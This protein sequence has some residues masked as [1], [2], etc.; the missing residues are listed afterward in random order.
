MA[1]G[2]VNNIYTA[3]MEPC[4]EGDPMQEWRFS[5]FNARG[6][7]YEDLGNENYMLA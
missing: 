6:I 3:V 7:K 4:K 5:R 1:I 2:S